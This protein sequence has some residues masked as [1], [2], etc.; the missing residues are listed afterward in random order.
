MS[1]RPNYQVYGGGQSLLIALGLDST[2]LDLRKEMEQATGISTEQYPIESLKSLGGLANSAAV[3][4][5]DAKR[6]SQRFLTFFLR[7]DRGPGMLLF[8]RTLTNKKIVEINCKPA[9]SIHNVKRRIQD[10]TGIPP[11]QQRLLFAGKELEDNM[12][13][14]QNFLNSEFVTHPRS[15]LDWLRYPK[16]K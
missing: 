10:E 3:F 16:S 4:G 1:N 11:E 8:V 6:H 7:N 13:N 9:D 12:A 15:Y 14:F 5:Q 2:I